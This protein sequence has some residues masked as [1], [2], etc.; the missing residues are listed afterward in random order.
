MLRLLLLLLLQRTNGAANLRLPSFLASNMVLQRGNATI[1][2]W[3]VAGESIEVTV[4]DAAAGSPV[5]NSSAVANAKDG[6]WRVSVRVDTPMTNTTVK[7]STSTK[8][9]LSLTN[10]AFGDVILCSG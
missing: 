9:S 2:G 5:A 7:V 4:I 8:D 1:W 10:V 6:S 3:A